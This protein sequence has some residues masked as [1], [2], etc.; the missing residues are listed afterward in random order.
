MG[1]PI[2]AMSRPPSPRTL[3]FPQLT[4]QESSA[5]S[6]VPLPTQGSMAGCVEALASQVLP[7]ARLLTIPILKDDAHSAIAARLLVAVHDPQGLHL[8][9]HE[10]ALLHA[11]GQTAVS[12]GPSPRP[13]AGGGE[14]L[15]GAWDLPDF[16]QQGAGVEWG[17]Q[18]GQG[19]Q[20]G[21]LAHAQVHQL[22]GLGLGGLL[23][24][25]FDNVVQGLQ[26]A[27]CFPLAGRTG[28]CRGWTGRSRLRAPAG[29]TGFYS[30]GAWSYSAWKR[31]PGEVVE[32]SQGCEVPRLTCFISTFMW[33]VLPRQ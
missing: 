10:G 25:H 32:C 6:R 18:V 30:D 4:F 29:P 2:P 14:A 7:G 8:G 17:L 11:A 27:Q 24:A 12:S 3:S 22:L 13:G 21:L 15:A 33:W 9:V 19:L 5:P 28:G 20:V 23:G 26:F 1:S 31:S 16:S